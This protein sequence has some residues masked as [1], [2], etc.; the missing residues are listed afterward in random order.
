MGAVMLVALVVG[1]GPIWL[2]GPIGL[3]FRDR[4]VTCSMHPDLL[5]LSI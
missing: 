5:P 1:I 2:I 3:R 4:E